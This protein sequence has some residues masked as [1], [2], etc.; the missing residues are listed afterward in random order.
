MPEQ[1]ERPVLVVDL[2]GQY[3]Q[4]IARRVREARVY[5]EIVSHRASVEEVRARMLALGA[6]AVGQ[7][8]ELPALLI[9]GQSSLLEEPQIAQ[10]VAKMRALFRTLDEKE[11]V[12]EVLDRA[13]RAQEL[14]IFIGAESGGANPQAL[15]L[16][17]ANRHGLIAGATGAVAGAE[18]VAERS[19]EGRPSPTPLTALTTVSSSERLRAFCSTSC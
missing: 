17:R 14:T 8:A 16:K 11:R 5:S 19:F 10:D 6:R 13:L 15:E 12:L 3:S 18:G 9:E 1:E 7:E 4:L 2:G